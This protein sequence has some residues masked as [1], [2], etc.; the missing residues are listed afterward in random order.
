[1]MVLGSF[2]GSYIGHSICGPLTGV[3]KRR[4]QD[5]DSRRYDYSGLLTVFTQERSHIY[6]V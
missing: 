3:K 2:F 1:M 4:G 6:T 5:F